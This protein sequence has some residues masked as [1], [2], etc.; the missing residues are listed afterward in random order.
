MIYFQKSKIGGGEK[1]RKKE[2]LP[3]FCGDGKR[4]CDY[5]VVPCRELKNELTKCPNFL[6]H[7][8]AEQ[9]LLAAVTL[10]DM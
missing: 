9:S 7:I 1:P 6:D 2:S 10:S 4:D 8:P 3:G 5:Q